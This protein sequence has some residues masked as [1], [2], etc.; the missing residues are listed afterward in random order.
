M[1]KKTKLIVIC[2]IALILLVITA[3]IFKVFILD[4]NESENDDSYSLQIDMINDQV[5][6][7]VMV[8]GEEPGFRKDFEWRRI[9]AISKD[10]LKNDILHGYRWLII[11]DQDGAVEMTDDELLLIKDK[12]EEN[13]LNMLYIGEKYLENFKRLGFTDGIDDG[14]YSFAYIG[15]DNS[16]DLPQQKN[17]A[18][19]GMWTETDVEL[20]KYNNELLQEIIVNFIYEYSYK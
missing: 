11:F 5:N 9:D 16:A 19:H 2:A 15:I 18:V 1:Q 10:S 4:N 12:V 20:Q 7:D 13:S 17:Y 8:Y 6:V 3:I 14:E